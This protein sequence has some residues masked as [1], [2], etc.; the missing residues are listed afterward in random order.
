MKK[1]I[2]IH[3]NEQNVLNP[4]EMKDVKGG[5]KGGSSGSWCN[6]SGEWVGPITNCSDAGCERLYG[7]GATCE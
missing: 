6:V 4:R 3:L 2:R 7:S 1:L 5:T